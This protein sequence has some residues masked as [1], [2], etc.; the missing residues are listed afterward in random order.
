MFAEQLG[1]SG[2][3]LETQHLVIVHAQFAGHVGLAPAGLEQG[4]HDRRH[5][6]YAVHAACSV[7]ADGGGDALAVAFTPGAYRGDRQVAVQTLAQR[8]LGAAHAQAVKAVD[9]LVAPVGLRIGD[10]GL[11]ESVGLDGQ[12][13]QSHLR[14]RDGI[15]VV[16]VAGDAL[17]THPLHAIDRL[18]G[19]RT[20]RVEQPADPVDGFNP[21]GK[22]Q[23]VQFAEQ[24]LGSLRQCL[25]LCHGLSS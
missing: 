11:G 13:Q 4:H 15:G 20:V 10:D 17:G 7:V 23:P 21:L 25:C 14:W 1:Q 24:R 2:N 16:V 3:L 5:R 6:Q 12:P 8:A 19:E 18:F 22:R 9:H